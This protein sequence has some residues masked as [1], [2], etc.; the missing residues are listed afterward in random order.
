MDDI[1]D[2]I[3]DKAALEMVSETKTWSQ[4]YETLAID[5]IDINYGKLWKASNFNI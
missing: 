4:S 3:S 5:R 1:L 2:S